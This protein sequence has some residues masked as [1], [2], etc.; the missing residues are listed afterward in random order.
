MFPLKIEFRLG[1]SFKLFLLCLSGFRLVISLLY[2]SSDPSSSFSFVDPSSDSWSLYLSRA[3]IRA[4]HLSLSF[5]VP[6]RELFTLFELWLELFILFC[7]PKSLWSSGSVNFSNLTFC[8][9]ISNLNLWIIQFFNFD[10]RVIQFFNFDL[11]VTQFSIFNFQITKFSISTVR[12]FNF[13][14]P[15]QDKGIILK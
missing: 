14:F 10:P 2:S 8:P 6:T 9:P 7:W 4:L 3:L 11:R 15:V 13:H 1:F 12:S 5:R